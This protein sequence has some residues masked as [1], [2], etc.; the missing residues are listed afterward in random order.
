MAV[1]AAGL[2]F[3]GIL[4]SSFASISSS[5]RLQSNSSSRVTRSAS[6]ALSA[7][8]APISARI[9]L[10]WSVRAAIRRRV[11]PAT[12]ARSAGSRSM[13]SPPICS[14]TASS[15]VALALA[16]RPDV[17]P[18]RSSTAAARQQPPLRCI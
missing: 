13:I 1:S 11:G 2:G 8:S 10:I 17:R 15:A 12:A 5:R 6:A 18:H 3:C 16:D 14:R 7:L 4:V 9:S